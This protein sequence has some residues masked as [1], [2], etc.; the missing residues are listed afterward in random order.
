MGHSRPLTV[1]DILDLDMMSGWAPEVVAGAAHLDRPV[2]WLH[3][4]EVPDI[5]VML[6]GG[7][8]VLTTGSLLS[9]DERAQAEYVESLHRADVAAIVLGLGRAFPTVPAPMRRAAQRLGLPFVVLHRPAP[10]ARLIEEVQPRLLYTKYAAVSLSDRMRAS[11][12]AL[13]LSGAGLQQLLDEIVGY[14]GG[15]VV[16]T[17]L[18][19]R[20]LA[21]AGDQDALSDLLR[22]WNR[23]ARQLGDL[24]GAE[25]VTITPNGWALAAL[26]ARGRR[27]GRLALFGYRGSEEVGRVLA[28]RA[29]EALV[30]HRLL[31]DGH[32]WEDHGAQSLLTD[33][34]SGAARPEQLPTRA[35][36]AGLPVGGRTFVP[37]VVRCLDPAPGAEAVVD[38]VRRAVADRSVAG[39]VAR[40][41]T[42]GTAAVLSVP[43]E[44][45][46]DAVLHK[47]A[48]RVHE[49]FAR[50]GGTAVVGAGFVCPA[51]ADLPRSFAEAVHVADAAVAGPPAGPVA[52]L[53]D[54]RLRGLVRV[55]RDEPELQAFIARELGPLLDHPHLLDVL[56]TYLAAGRNKSQAAQAHHV[57][58]PAMYRRLQS[59]EEL[60]ATDLDDWDQ[61]TTLYVA[62]LAYDAQHTPGTHPA[63]PPAG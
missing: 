35:R 10:F 54:V 41:D 53:R 26:E 37:L 31:G 56:R 17:N 23:V 50:A 59:I 12:T 30:V 55:L 18:A 4:A 45:D 49:R 33:L 28:D 6:S 62:L 11:L 25:P 22:D 63:P 19:D 14:S 16:L 52:R 15:P 21:T 40:I 47:V 60:L 34:A 58:R 13:N 8:M 29:A 32:D 20:V 46:P 57:S 3:V 5:A 1:R 61:L 7:E 24:A 42:R 36:A 44:Q 38:L 9:G 43:R 27:W 2:R 39:L 51:L 48:C